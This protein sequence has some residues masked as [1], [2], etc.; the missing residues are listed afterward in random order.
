MPRSS[1][2]IVGASGQGL[3]SIG[4][5]LAKAFKRSGYC[6]FGYREYMSLIKGGHGSYQIDIS[7]DQIRSSEEKVDML[8][9]LNHHGFEHNLHDLKKGGVIVH[10]TTVWAFSKEEEA[11]LKKQ[12]ISVVYLPIAEILKKMNA[13][14]ILAN[15]VFSAFVWAACKGDIELL[16]TLVGEKFAHKKDLLEGN[17]QAIDEGTKALSEHAS[18]VIIKLPKP[19]K[20]WKDDLLLT[21]SHAMGLGL[22]H[23]GVRMYAGYPMTPSSPLL[24]FIA[25]VQNETGMIIKQ[26]EDEITAIQMVSGAMHMGTRALT[27]TSGGGFDLMTE[28]I[29]LNGMIENPCVIVLAQRPGPATGLPTW[30]AQGDLF[31][32]IH[33]GHGEFPRCVISVSDSDDAFTLMNDAF[34]IAEQY[35]TQVIVMTDKHIAE[36]IY[37]QKPYVQNADIRRGRLIVEQGELKQL[38]ST[39]R[40]DPTAP[41]GISKRWLPG[42]EAA[43]YAA[44]GDEHNADGSVDESSVNALEQM[45]KRMKK[46]E[47][48]RK[49]TPA[50]LWQGAEESDLLIVSWGSTRSVI[51][52]AM[53]SSK[54]KGAKIAHL[55]YQYLWP[56]HM[57]LLRTAMKSAK[58]TMIIEG[59]ATAQLQKL[60]RME[61]GI[62]I[63]DTLL[64][65]D[66]RPF[67]YDELVQALSSRLA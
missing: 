63:E 44:Q 1:I 14:P 8:I 49:A 54:L 58:K 15:V 7:A 37:T 18:D 45:Q 4:E 35:Q 67:F 11:H 51:E 48:L 5:I 61:S 57:D 16:K 21:G 25:E 12:K 55:H 50:P 10:D 34:N 26:A 2:K 29:S 66:G 41:D 13:K 42:S 64:K 52:D 43:T 6:V 33:G 36:G 47:A 40:Y 17:M 20:E 60:I 24:S 23:A 19:K 53:H 62:D 46:F 22:I 56:L 27:G 3:I 65:Y 39:D 30:T 38:S 32:A 59:N 31:L 9:T 28:T